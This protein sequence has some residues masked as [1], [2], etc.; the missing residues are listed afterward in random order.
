MYPEDYLDSYLRFQ[1]QS[2]QAWY[3]LKN[4]LEMLNMKTSL[5]QNDSFA[6]SMRFGLWLAVV[7]VCKGHRLSPLII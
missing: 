4:K 1:T 3:L 5:Y 2:P 7:F 6:F